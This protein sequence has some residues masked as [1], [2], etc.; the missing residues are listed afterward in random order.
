MYGSLILLV[1]SL[2]QE[3]GMLWSMRIGSSMTSRAQT[4]GD[5]LATGCRSCRCI[6]IPASCKIKVLVASHVT[7]PGHDLICSPAL[8]DY[9]EA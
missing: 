5:A 6:S 9:V 7:L 1:Q 2:R 3:L 4:L 8:P